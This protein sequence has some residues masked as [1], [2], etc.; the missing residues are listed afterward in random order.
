MPVL[1]AFDVREI[2]REDLKRLV[3]K[4]D[5]KASE[6]FYL[7]A[8]GRRR[9]FG[10]KTATN[11]WGTVC[12]LFRDAQKAKDV[13][14]CVRDDNPASEVAGPDAGA[15]KSKVYL[16]PS[17]FD[18]V[19]RHERVPLRWRRLFALAVYTYARAGELAALDWADVDLEHGIIH[20]HRSLDSKRG[21]GMKATKSEAA[22]RVPIEPELMPLLKVMRAEDRG[23]GSVVRLPR[24]AHLSRSLRMYLRRAGITRKDLLTS[25]ETR[26]AMTFHDLRATGITWCACRGDEA[27]KI[28]YRA[29]HAD[30]ETTRIYLREAENLADAFGTVFPILPPEMLRSFATVSQRCET[31]KDNMLKI[32][33]NVVEAPGI[34]PGSENN[35]LAHLRT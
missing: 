8:A 17:E 15:E 29:G 33:A 27:L 7:T 13:T 12:A 28:M 31:D 10:C 30:F 25:D 23:K 14:L 1:G 11:A 21:R 3:A 19:I 24:G 18:S 6:G 16:W 34:E 32:L 5:A 9:P 4:L 26:K 2:A 20:I 35:L 22:R